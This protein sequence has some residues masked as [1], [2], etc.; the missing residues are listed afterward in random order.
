MDTL[1]L[2]AWLAALGAAVLLTSHALTLVR[3]QIADTL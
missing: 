1:K 2:I 3:N